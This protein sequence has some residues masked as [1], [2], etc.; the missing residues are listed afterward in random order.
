[1]TNTRRRR[2]ELLILEDV[3][4][5]IEN[6][7][8][9]TA[10]FINNDETDNLKVSLDVTCQ[11]NQFRGEVVTPSLVSNWH[12]THARNSQELVGKI[13]EV[14]NIEAADKREDTFYL[15]EHEP[16]VKYQLEIL[17][18][19]ENKVHVICE[20]IS[21]IDGYSTPSTT[22][23]FKIDCYLPIITGKDDWAKHGL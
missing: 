23:D 21:V 18:I 11:K 22:A 5:D 15:Y 9:D 8:R 17:G 4:F 16:L 20:G 14:E 12:E 19:E 7:T 3:Q 2:V 6:N 1:M 10:F 13:F